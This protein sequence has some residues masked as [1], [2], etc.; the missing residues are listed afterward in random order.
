MIEGRIT[1]VVVADSAQPFVVA[2]I[3]HQTTPIVSDEVLQE[4][5]GRGKLGRSFV[6]PEELASGQ[7]A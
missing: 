5:V 6:A 3:S 7:E 2:G 1:D 4:E